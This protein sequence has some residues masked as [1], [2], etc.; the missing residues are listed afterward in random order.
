MLFSLM[1]FTLSVSSITQY[2]TYAASRSLFLGGGRRIDQ[3]KLA[4]EKYKAL[5]QSPP[6]DRFFQADLFRIAAASD[7]ETPDKGMGLNKSFTV[8]GG[9]PNLFYGVWT[10]FIP[11]VLE[12]DTVWGNTEEEENFFETAVGSYLGREPTMTE[13][14]EF[15]KKRWEFISRKHGVIPSAVDPSGF[16]EVFHDNGC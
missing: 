9:E 4:R 1:T 6:F 14:E 16:Y 13:C 10:K 11:K 2:I 15:N 7:L 3:R 8:S 5:T 12:V